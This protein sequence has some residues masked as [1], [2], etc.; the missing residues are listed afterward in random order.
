MQISI[1]YLTILDPIVATNTSVSFYLLIPNSFSSKIKNIL[2]IPELKKLILN[3][4]C[5]CIVILNKTSNLPIDTPTAGIY[6]EE[7]IP[8]NPSYLPPP[9]IEPTLAPTRTAS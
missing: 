4:Y 1:L 2:S 8:T 6:L 5:S 7:N 3:I 9:P